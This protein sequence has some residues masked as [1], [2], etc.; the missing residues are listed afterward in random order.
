MERLDFGGRR[1]D[2]VL[3]SFQRLGDLFFWF[4]LP[5]L[6]DFDAIT[7]VDILNVSKVPKDRHGASFSNE[8]Y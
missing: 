1:F 6:I 4:I 2:M 8:C 7:I 5:E 3:G